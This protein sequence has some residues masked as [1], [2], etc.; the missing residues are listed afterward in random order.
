MMDETLRRGFQA[1]LGKELYSAYLYYAMA[2]HFDS[3]GMP[4]LQRW[5]EV[6]ALEELSHADAFRHFLQFRHEMPVLPRIKKPPESWNGY[7]DVFEGA[8]EHEHMITRSIEKLYRRA[9]LVDD[10]YAIYLL[11][12]FLDEQNE[13]LENVG[14]ALDLLE[15]AHSEKALWDAIRKIG[16]REDAKRFK[17][18]WDELAE[19]E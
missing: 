12:L 1:Q 2:N 6:Q 9:E 13:E 19:Q 18:D 15:S 11:D 16:W 17:V 5:M 8:L 7:I 3:M 14:S 10:G 4:W